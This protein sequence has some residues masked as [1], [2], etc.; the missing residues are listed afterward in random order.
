V[1][2]DKDVEKAKAIVDDYSD[3]AKRLR[4]LEA[5]MPEPPKPQAPAPA[6]SVRKMPIR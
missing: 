1:D 6:I 3:I 2:V 4:A 5:K